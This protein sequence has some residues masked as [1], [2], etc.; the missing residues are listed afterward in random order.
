MERSASELGLKATP[1]TNFYSRTRHERTQSR[2]PRGIHIAMWRTV[3]EHKRCITRAIHRITINKWTL[4]VQSFSFFVWTCVDCDSVLTAPLAGRRAMPSGPLLLIP[5]VIWS[6]GHTLAVVNRIILTNCESQWETCSTLEVV[7]Y[8]DSQFTYSTPTQWSAFAAV[9]IF[10]KT[11][12]FR[13]NGP[14]M[15]VWVSFPSRANRY[16]SDRPD[17]T[18]FAVIWIS[19]KI[20]WNSIPMDAF[21]CNHSTWKGS[22]LVT[23]LWCKFDRAT[24]LRDFMMTTTTTTLWSR[25]ADRS[26]PSGTGASTKNR[27]GIR[28]I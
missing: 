3:R 19:W 7:S 21:Y 14:G 17:H 5:A 4:P 9:W 1:E 25:L 18:L 16:Q 11:H 22:S 26:S 6:G 28:R 15:N 12:P 24:I 10:E 23:G 20:P 27:K 13:N 8:G 2:E